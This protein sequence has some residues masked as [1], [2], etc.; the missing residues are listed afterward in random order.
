MYQ[1]FSSARICVG[2]EVALGRK[3]DGTFTARPQTEAIRRDSSQALSDMRELLRMSG[4]VLSCFRD[5]IPENR[6]RHR[7]TFTTTSRVALR[8]YMPAFICF[9]CSRSGPSHVRHW[10]GYKALT[11]VSTFQFIAG[12]NYKIWWW[13]SFKGKEL[14][15]GLWLKK[16]NYCILELFCG[17]SHVVFYVSPE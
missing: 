17:L 2:F 4:R 13:Y 10:P 5:C 14:S 11:V 1:V 7:K 15:T 8:R 3:S 12:H 6:I 9:L 16:L